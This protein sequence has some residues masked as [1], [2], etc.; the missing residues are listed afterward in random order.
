MAVTEE[1]VI[2]YCDAM[3]FYLYIPTFRT[4]LLPPC[5]GVFSSL[6]IEVH[7]KNW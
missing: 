3:Q 6:K 4:N 5:P 7:Q 2:M 1:Y